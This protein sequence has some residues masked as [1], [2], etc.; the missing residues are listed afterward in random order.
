MSETKE[1]EET[2]VLTRQHN[3][4]PNQKVYY[5][6]SVDED[7]APFSSVTDEPKDN[8]VFRFLEIS[9]GVCKFEVYEDA[10]EMVLNTN[11]YLKYSC[12]Y[13]FSRGGE[14]KVVTTEKGIAEQKSDGK[15]YVKEPA[16]VNLK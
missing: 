15:W 12:N 3:A 4:K 16:T 10:Y 14:T 2:V 7:G 8:S 9:Q 11:D 13:A 6:G 5:A 1:E